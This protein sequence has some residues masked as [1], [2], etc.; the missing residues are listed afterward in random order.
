MARLGVP[1]GLSTGKERGCLHDLPCLS[2]LRSTGHPQLYPLSSQGTHPYPQTHPPKQ[3]QKH[4]ARDLAHT[5]MFPPRKHSQR[6]T[7]SP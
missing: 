7:P 6:L 4:T 1:V 3:P 2:A 5:H